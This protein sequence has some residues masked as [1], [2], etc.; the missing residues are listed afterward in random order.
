MTQVHHLRIELNLTTKANY[1]STH[2]FHH[3]H[4]LECTDVGL[5]QKKNLWWRACFH[6]F[7]K[8]LATQ[9]SLIFYLAVKLSIRECPSTTLTELNIGLGV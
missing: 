7:I 3:R 6:K 8:H 5:T 4:Q 2:P 1:F 9:M